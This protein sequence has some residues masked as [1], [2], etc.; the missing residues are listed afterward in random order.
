MSAHTT[1]LWAPE[2]WRGSIA[3]VAGVTAANTVLK[4]IMMVFPLF[5]CRQS[6][7][8]I[9]NMMML[10]WYNRSDAESIEW[11]VGVCFMTLTTLRSLF[12]KLFIYYHITV[13]LIHIKWLRYAPLTIPLCLSLSMYAHL[14][15]MRVLLPT[16]PCKC[17]SMPVRRRKRAQGQSAKAWGQSWCASKAV[18]TILYGWSL[19]NSLSQLNRCCMLQLEKTKALICVSS[20]RC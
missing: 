18:K 5:N 19:S 6:S 20:F 2:T 17:Q 16:V 9:N 14:F 8:Y 13:S 7:A 1:Y 12:T 10:K 4:Q 11:L 15:L 3:A